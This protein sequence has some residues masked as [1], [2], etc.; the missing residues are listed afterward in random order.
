MKKGWKKAV[1]GTER[2]ERQKME[3]KISTDSEALEKVASGASEV[4]IL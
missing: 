3:L 2:S 1:L 4:P